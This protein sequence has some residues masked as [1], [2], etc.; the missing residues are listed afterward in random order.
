MYDFVIRLPYL[1]YQL[2]FSIIHLINSGW[3]NNPKHYFRATIFG[4]DYLSIG[5]SIRGKGIE[6]ECI[7]VDAYDMQNIWWDERDFTFTFLPNNEEG[8]YIVYGK[9]DRNDFHSKTHVLYVGESGDDFRTRFQKHDYRALFVL[10]ATRVVLYK[11]KD[12][13]DAERI[14]F[15]KAKILDL[16]PLLNKP[17]S[18]ENDSIL[19]DYRAEVYHN[20]EFNRILNN[21]FGTDK[22]V[23]ELIDNIKKGK[24]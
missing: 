9:V 14:L 6:N 17:R 10:F 13:E 22:E 20:P 2:P 4:G 11:F 24:V 23:L 1:H 8:V 5:I 12:G 15:E 3:Y 7:R 21:G 19:N 16:K 18:P